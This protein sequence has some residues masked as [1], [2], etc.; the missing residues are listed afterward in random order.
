MKWLLLLLVLFIGCGSSER[1]TSQV[2]IIEV[3]REVSK[4]GLPCLKVTVRNE[5]QKIA[6]MIKCEVYAK[7]GEMILDSNFDLFGG[8]LEPGEKVK[9]NITFYELKSH[10]DYKEL[11]Y[12]LNWTVGGRIF[13]ARYS[14]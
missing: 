14:K 12:D 5:G 2:K 11:T 4:Y 1:K 13:R 7:D 6:S 9:L 3:K 10:R 8:E